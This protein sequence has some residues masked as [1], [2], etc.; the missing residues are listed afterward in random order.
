ME[1]ENFIKYLENRD[2]QRKTID[3]AVKFVSQFLA[4]TKKEDLQIAKPDVLNFLKYLK[5]K[6]IQNSYRYQYLNALNHYFTML[7]KNGQIAENPCLLLKIRGIRRKK[8]Y[9]IYASEALDQLFDNYY[10]LFVRNFDDGYM[11]KNVRKLSA[12]NRERNA[13]ILSVLIYQGTTTGEVERI[14]M[15]DLDFMKATL[16]IRGG[17]CS[18]P[19]ILPLK[20]CQIGL[21]MNYLQTIRPQLV[22]Y[23]A[24]ESELL[25]LTSQDVGRTG[26]KNVTKNS[27]NLANN[28][29]L[30][31]CKQLKIID[32]QFLNF[33]QVRASVIT[34]WLKTEGLRKTQYLA[35]HR[36]ISSTENYLPNNLDNLIDDINKLHP[37]DF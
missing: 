18:N 25:F 15:G 19:R 16:K 30:V 8:L 11:P 7:Y 5:T 1:K 34:N 2:L 17:L 22:E 12:W 9:K 32:K 3:Y 29:F 10:Q 35:G 13:L 33:K 26:K 27:L 20:A 36:F 37:F 23:H 4:W 28:T 21:I 31:L 14:E 24:K 6:N